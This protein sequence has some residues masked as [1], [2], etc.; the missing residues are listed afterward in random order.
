MFVAQL[1][2][3]RDDWESKKEKKIALPVLG[4]LDEDKIETLQPYDDALVITLKIGGYDLKR[5]LVD[6]G[7]AVEV[8]YLDLYKGL[9]LKLEDLTS[10]DSPLMSF[11]GK[12]V[13]PMVQIRLPIQT[14]SNMVEVDF[15]MVDAYSPYT[16]VVARP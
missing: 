6:Q 12:I 14:G 8:M 7:S 16:A 15:I 1:P 4:F 5:V 3:E 11:E 10:Y 13:T 9:N 2:A